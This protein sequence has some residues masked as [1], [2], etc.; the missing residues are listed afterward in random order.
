MWL[1][2]L[3]EMFNM[4]INGTKDFVNSREASDLIP[5]MRGYSFE[6]FY[7]KNKL[8]NAR[9]CPSEQHEE[10]YQYNFK[11]FYLML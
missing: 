6:A 2:E 4:E 8:K 9:F 5:K 11:Q 3:P 10:Q 1:Y 7:N